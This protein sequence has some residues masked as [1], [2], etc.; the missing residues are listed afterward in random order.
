MAKDKG[1]KADKGQKK[2]KKAD[3]KDKAAR[4]AEKKAG[5]NGGKGSAYRLVTPSLTVNDLAAS[6]KFYQS[7]GFAIKE[8]W[9]GPDGVVRGY[10]LE[11]GKT[12]LMIGQDDFAKGHDRKKGEGV[13]L[14]FQTK[15]T[16]DDV[17]ARVK[18]AGLALASEPADQPWGGRTFDV[19]DPDGY[20]H[21]VASGW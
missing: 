15:E 9:K 5:K 21:T 19:V 4:K 1:K 13:R 17:A 20:K 12:A 18:T 7:L 11:A 2:A 14:Y 6:L 16:V 10:E 8:T 3:K